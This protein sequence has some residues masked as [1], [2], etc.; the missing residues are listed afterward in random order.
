MAGSTAGRRD[1]DRLPKSSM[2][3]TREPQ[4]IR[5]P[6]ATD[7]TSPTAGSSSSGL[8]E[9]GCFVPSVPG[10]LGW[11][12][13]VAGSHHVGVADAAVSTMDPDFASSFVGDNP[14]GPL[15]GVA[16]GRQDVAG[17][18]R[19]RLNHLPP[20]V[21]VG[22]HMPSCLCHCSPLADLQ[23]ECPLSPTLTNEHRP[24]CQEFTGPCFSTS[25][26]DSGPAPWQMSASLFVKAIDEVYVTA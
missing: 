18:F 11:M 10:V 20:A 15:L 13:V 12:R 8:S 2:L 5:W 26:Q 3:Q 17:P 9:K 22:D 19:A 14:L 21:A 16:L 7:P 23:A 1:S 6:R 4:G 24:D 25:E